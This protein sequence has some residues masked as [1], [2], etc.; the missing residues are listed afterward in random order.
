MTLFE[1]GKTVSLLLFLV[2]ITSAVVS[3][4]NRLEE[5]LNLFQAIC[6]SKFFVKTTMV[7]LSTY[8]IMYVVSVA[9]CRSYF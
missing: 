3:S 8:N 4:K 5:S 6:N 1:D 9:S 2:M 7:W